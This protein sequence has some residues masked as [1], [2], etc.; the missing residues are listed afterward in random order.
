LF[1]RAGRTGGALLFLRKEE[2]AYLHLLRGRGV[3]LHQIPVLR[4]PE[5]IQSTA[6]QREVDDEQSQEGNNN[7]ASDNDT[8]E[9]DVGSD[10]GS[11]DDSDNEEEADNGLDVPIAPVDG[12]LSHVVTDDVVTFATERKNVMLK[13]M[14]TVAMSDR[15]VL[16]AG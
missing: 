8:M 16:E 9:E 11:D 15:S 12:N 6:T 5:D 13:A 4:A 10:D 7:E 1:G 14:Q 2:E 3:P